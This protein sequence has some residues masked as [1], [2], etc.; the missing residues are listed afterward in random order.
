MVKRMAGSFIT[1]DVYS[2]TLEWWDI[3]AKLNSFY[4]KV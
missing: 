3:Q 4:L 2:C 1:N